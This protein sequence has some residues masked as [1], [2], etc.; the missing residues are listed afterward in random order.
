M[1]GI[2]C[3]SSGYKDLLA[4]L[5]DRDVAKN[6][7]TEVLNGLPIC[8]PM[9]STLSLEGQKKVEAQRKKSPEWGVQVDYTNEKG[10]TVS[11]GSPSAVVKA[12]GLKMSETQTL[13]DG[14]KCKA[15]DVVDIFRL[16]GYIV[17]CEDEKGLTLD[18]QKASAGG[19]AMHIIHPNV[20]TMK[21][22]QYGK[23]PE[24]LRQQVEVGRAWERP[25]K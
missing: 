17:A 6:I 5:I 9:P 1:A 4:T 23:L 18:C 16:Q 7:L 15:L 10:D 21:K 3:I 14:E 8:E 11:Y 19:K 12:L 25:G 13:C 20:A 24:T 22:P 2:D